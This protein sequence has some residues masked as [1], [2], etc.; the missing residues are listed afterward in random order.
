[1]LGRLVLLLLQIAGGYFLG[2]IVMGYIP[3]RGDLSLFVYAVVVSVIIFLIGVV[4]AQIVKDV[5]TP[6]PHALTSALILAL[7]MALIWS[8]VPPLVPDLPWSKVP[9]RW[10]VLIGAVLG[11]F[12]KR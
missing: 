3:I 1:M 10:A 5:A 4:A 8:F 9:D 7:I 2:N 11:Y 6:P 12:A